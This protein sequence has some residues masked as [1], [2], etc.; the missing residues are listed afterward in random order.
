[1]IILTVIGD[2]FIKTASLQNSFSG[3]PMLVFGSIIYGLTGVGWFFVMRQMK[4]STLG[5][6]YAVGCVLLLTLL[7]VLYFKEKISSME[8]VGIILAIVSL[9]ILFRFA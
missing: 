8:I 5:V 6:F 7:S 4:L 1:M 9:I 3:W 2:M